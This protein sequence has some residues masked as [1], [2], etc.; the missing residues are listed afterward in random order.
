MS[1]QQQVDGIGGWFVNVVFILLM[2]SVDSRSFDSMVLNSTA[3]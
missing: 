1:G 2:E 3:A